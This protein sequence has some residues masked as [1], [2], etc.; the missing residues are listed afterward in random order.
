MRTINA[1]AETLHE[2]RSFGPAWDAGRRGL[3]VTNGFYEWARAAKGKTGQRYAIY[4]TK[5]TFTCYG[6]LWNVGTHSGETLHS[7]AIITTEPNA[8]LAPIHNRMPAI[9]AKEDYGAWLGETEATPE[10]LK[11][12]LKPCPEEGMEVLKVSTKVNSAKNEGIE[13]MEQTA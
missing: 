12:L 13:L 10:E 9:L 5:E 11:S 2:L 8:L 4:R 3:V 1:R 7:C 6:C